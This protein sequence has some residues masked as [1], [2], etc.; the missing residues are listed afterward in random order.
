MAECV[1]FFDIDGTLLNTGGA[2]Q[3]AMERAL[4]EDFRLRFPFEGVFTAGRTDRGIVD[5]IF[6]RCGLPDSD[7]ERERFMFSYL[8]RLPECLAQVPGALLPGVSDLLET[9]AAQQE[10]LLSLLTG[11]YAEG[12][13]IKLRHF[14]ID[15]YFRPGGFGDRHVD[16]DDVARHAAHVIREALGLSDNH[17]RM[18][19]VGDTPADIRCARAIGAVAIAV[20]TGHYSESQLQAHTPDFLFADF[21][22]TEDVLRKLLNQPPAERT[23]EDLRCP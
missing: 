9:L 5:E 4:T 7:A 13:W 21:S 17:P 11:N 6:T 23:S 19:V 18:I 20:A 15:R 8:R 16:R 14:G 1:V 10:L 12:A 3:L 22:E 2:G